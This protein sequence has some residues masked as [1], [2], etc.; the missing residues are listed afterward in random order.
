[1]QLNDS[2]IKTL[3][4]FYFQILIVPI[5]REWLINQTQSLHV[6]INILFY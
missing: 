6:Y 4:S 5:L 3:E 1:M 2:N